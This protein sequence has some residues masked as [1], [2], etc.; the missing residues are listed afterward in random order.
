[1]KPEFIRQA[2]VA[3]PPEMLAEIAR[4]YQAGAKRQDLRDLFRCG[5]STITSAL[6]KH[7]ISQ[8]RTRVIH[9][10]DVELAVVQ[11]YKDGAERKD[12]ASCTGV[13]NS[14]ITWILKRH[15][16]Q[17][18]HARR[19]PVPDLIA[20]RVCK[21]YKEGLSYSQIG[22]ALGIS[23]NSAA[24][25]IHR[26]KLTR[27]EEMATANRR[28]AAAERNPRPKAAPKPKLVAVAS[29]DG[30]RVIMVPEAEAEKFAARERA[31]HA[32]TASDDPVMKLGVL[33][34]KW[35][36]GEPG[37]AGFSFCGCR[38]TVSNRK[39]GTPLYCADHGRT[40]FRP[41]TKADKNS[42]TEL[43]RSLRRYF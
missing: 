38:A 32:F 4:M 43:A 36:I 34:C 15:G 37:T 23:R 9:T 30:E 17:R 8:R 42:A 22:A 33:D 27:P 41:A 14:T 35:P 26:N 2:G 3:A 11:M 19:P 21:F 39:D 6:D 29:Q 10:P 7:G 13:P 20:E 1:M 25:I 28:R 16:V 40:A 24:G 31:P 18:T 12:I 5:N